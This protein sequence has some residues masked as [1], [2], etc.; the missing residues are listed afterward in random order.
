MCNIYILVLLSISLS[1]DIDVESWRGELQDW[2]HSDRE[3]SSRENPIKSGGKNCER[4]DREDWGGFDN[5]DYRG[6]KNGW[7]SGEKDYGSF[8]RKNCESFGD[9]N[10]DSSSTHWLGHGEDKKIK[11]PV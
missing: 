8:G 9:K 3:S 7:N 1:D 4:S 2:T 5:K 10:W 6:G 11:V